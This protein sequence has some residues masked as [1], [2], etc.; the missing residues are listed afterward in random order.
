MH[1][2]HVIALAHQRHSDLLAEADRRRFIRSNRRQHRSLR[3]LTLDARRQRAGT[4]TPAWGTSPPFHD[5]VT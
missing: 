1:P 2:N 5:L 4:S 3:D